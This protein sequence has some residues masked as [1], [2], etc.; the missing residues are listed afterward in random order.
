MP[1]PSDQSQKLTLTVDDAEAGQRLDRWLAA[2]VDGLSRVRVQQLIKDGHVT[3]ACGVVVASAPVKA[4]GSYEIV[5]PAARMT[6][7][8]PEN[9][10]LDIVFEDRDVIV[11]NKPAGLVVHPA[12][13]HETGTMVNALLAHCGESLSGIGG[14]R[15]PG[16]VHRLDKDTSGLLVVAKN[17]AAHAHLSEQFQSHGRDGRLIREYSALVWG[18]PTRTAGTINAP[19]SRSG[20]NRTKI[21]VDQNGRE[22]ITHYAVVETL[23]GVDGG[24]AVAHLRL[25]LETGRT[26]QIRVH[27]AH[28]RHPLLGDAIYGA[29]F[30][31]A[32]SRLPEAAAAALSTLNRQALHAATLGFEHPRTGKNMLFSSSLPADYQA[33]L[34]AFKPRVAEPKKR[35]RA[36]S[37]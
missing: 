11:I 16:I 28:I 25:Q 23:L 29:S 10:D 9:I 34:G 21:A 33:L 20:I 13:G 32:A 22:A 19:L 8:A 7:V 18:V 24:A 26:H 14:V 37:S 1:E 4:A 36:R 31:T 2:K 6:D 12:A 35:Q 30:K 15:R 3:S 5:V 17:D 27:M